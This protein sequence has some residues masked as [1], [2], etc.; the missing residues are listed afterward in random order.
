MQLVKGVTLL[1]YRMP[2]RPAVDPFFR[3]FQD[4]VI[5]G[6]AVAT[7]AA[8]L[9][10]KGFVPDMVG[11][12]IGW[13]ES[14]FLR[15]VFPESRILLFCEYFYQSRG[16]DYAFDPELKPGPGSLER[17]RLLNAPLLMAMSVC[18]WGITATEWQKS[19][20]PEDFRRRISVIHDGI[21]TTRVNPD[22]GAEFLLP[23]GRKLTREDK[24]VTYT[25]R[26]FE[27]YR[28][29][30]IFMRALPRILSENPG[31]EVVLVGADDVSY[32]PRLPEGKTYRRIAMDEVGAGL[33]LSR[34]H[35]LPTLDYDE[36]VKL[37]RISSAHVYLTYPFVLSWSL[38]EAM[39][40]GCV[41]IGSDTTPVTEVIRDGENGLLVDF[42]DPVAIASRVREVL[43]DSARFEPLR[44]R[45][46]EHVVANYDLKSV[47][48]NKHIALAESLA[49]GPPAR[50]AG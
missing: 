41:V 12:H 30:H 5:R 1:G 9:R 34:V 11:V 20:F 36:Y 29:F 7:A 24:V 42:F 23:N 35:F 48:L 28:G 4:H 6:R 26:N 27:P 38:L 32:S 39:A 43:A 15:D 46:R 22:A 2:E 49:N 25:T 19:R 18:D 13:G 45:A 14:L 31:A 3:S 10:A 37:L 16:G 17:L 21:D 47:C 40:A 33:D 50:P 44:Q 8:Q